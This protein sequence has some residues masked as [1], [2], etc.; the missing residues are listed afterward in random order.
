MIWLKR[1]LLVER[2]ALAATLVVA[3][4]GSAVFAALAFHSHS[5]CRRFA[6]GLGYNRSP[7]DVPAGN[8]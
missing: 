3:A 2:V 5:A 7:A 4:P 8:R 1:L 6:P